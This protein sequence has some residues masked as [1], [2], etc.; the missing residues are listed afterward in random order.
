MRGIYAGSYDP[1]T[2][3]HRWMFEQGMKLFDKFFIA[4]GENAHKA[5]SFTLNER[6]E[7]I[8]ELCIG[9]QN[10]EVVTIENKFLVKYAESVGANY[11]FRG[12]RN[13]GD[14]AYER[15]MRYVNSNINNDIQTIFMMSPRDL[16]EVSSSMVKGLVGADCWEEVIKQYVPE[17]VYKRMLKKFGHQRTRPRSLKKAL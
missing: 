4:V 14:Y 5:Y 15:G 3:G 7:M 2:N 11:I 6:V 17:P 10:V 16:V 13:E 12:I 9:H 8:K 1:P